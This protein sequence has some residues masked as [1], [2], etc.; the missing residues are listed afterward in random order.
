MPSEGNNGSVGVSVGSSQF[1][2]Q[3]SLNQ[4]IGRVNSAL[5]KMSTCND[6]SSKLVE[7]FS[8]LDM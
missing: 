2:Q 6:L 3:N 5:T 7:E 4:K 8:E 1:R